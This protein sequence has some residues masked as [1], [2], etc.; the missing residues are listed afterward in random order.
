MAEPNLVNVVAVKIHVPPA[1][2][3]LQINPATTLEHIQTRCGQ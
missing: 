3:I 1:L 2:E